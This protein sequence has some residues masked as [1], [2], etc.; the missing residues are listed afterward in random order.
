MLSEKIV[1]IDDD[2]RVIKSVKLAF[3]EYEIIDFTDGEEGL[4]YLRKPNAINIILLDVMMPKMDGL[5]VLSEIR[6][7][8]EDVGVIMMTGFGSKDVV[9]EALRNKA[10][11]YIDKPFSIMELKEKISNILR[12]KLY[13]QNFRQDKDD[14]VARIKNFIQHNYSN[15]NLKY[16]A[17]E[18]SLSPRY[19]SRLFN[20][21]NN[22][23]YRRYKLDI[24]MNQAKEMLTKSHL[25]VSEIA[26]KLGYKNPETFMRVFKRLMKM[27]PSEYR[28]NTNKMK[29]QRKAAV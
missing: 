11:D 14:Q 10:D 21:K 4:A 24:K 28:L 15:V 1:V 29:S 5:T 3:P 9:V 16:I 26:I 19:L 27:T 18:M 7:I 12:K 8:K 23:S 17:D 13:E 6:R 22:I 25:T 20:A 2:P